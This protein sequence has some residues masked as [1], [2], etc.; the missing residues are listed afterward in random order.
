MIQKL[1]W[2]Y[3]RNTSITHEQNESIITHLKDEM[4]DHIH[5][6]RLIDV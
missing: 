1:N 4:H 5:N 6:S 3:N 2:N